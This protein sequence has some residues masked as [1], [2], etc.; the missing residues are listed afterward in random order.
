MPKHT[1]N[2]PNS[3]WRLFEQYLKGIGDSLTNARRVLETLSAML[4]AYR[5]AETL[6]KCLYKSGDMMGT[7]PTGLS[8][9]RKQRD[10]LGLLPT[11]SPHI[12]GI[13]RVYPRSKA[14]LFNLS[15]TWRITRKM[16]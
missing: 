14:V 5:V 8:A 7:F 2:A 4:N 13:L 9:S 11:I 3:S 6:G 15:K 1:G 10:P 16:Q 12:S